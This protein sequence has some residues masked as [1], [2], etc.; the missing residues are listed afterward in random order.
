MKKI[1]LAICVPLLLAQ[2]RSTKLYIVRHAEKSTAPAKD[3]DL[4]AD[5]KARAQS[6]AGYLRNKDIKAIYTTETNRTRQ[7]AEPLSLKT[8]VPLT[9]YNNDTLPKFLYRVIDSE[10]NT[11]IVGHSNTVLKMLQELSLKS[12]I[13]EIADNDYDNLFIITV[14]SKDGPGGYDLRLKERTYGKKSPNTKDTARQVN[15]MQ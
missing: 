2:C 14:K 5:G 11:L 1:L 12:S 3:P 6:L 9:P 4:T 13:R 7:T 15:M 10:K 8:G